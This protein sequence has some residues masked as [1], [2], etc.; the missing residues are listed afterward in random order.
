MSLVSINNFE[1]TIPNMRRFSAG[2]EIDSNAFLIDAAGEKVAFVLNIKKTG[3]ITTALI[4]V[5]GVTTA[6]TLRVS[7]Q[8]VD[9]TTGEPTGTSYGGSTAGTIASPSANTTYEVSFGTSASGTKGD[10]AAIVIEFDATVGSLNICGFDI[11]LSSGQE[12]FP[13]SMLYTT[14][15]ADVVNRF[16]ICALGYS[17]I[18]Y[19]TNTLPFNSFGITSFNNSS[20]P[21]E[22]ALYFKFPYPTKI[23]G[24]WF[25]IDLAADCDI[26]LYDV[27]G[28]TVLATLSLDTDLRG[29]TDMGYYK[30]NFSFSI[31]IQ[32]NRWY[33]LSIKPTTTTNIG[34]YEFTVASAAIMD[35]FD[36]GQYIYH[37]QRTDAGAWTE[38]TTKRIYGGILCDAFEDGNRFSSD[39]SI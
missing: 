4:R 23:S 30:M 6:Q 36:C 32:A 16:P 28:T 7:L 19:N 33:R 38:T 5:G 34:I 15:W 9:L 14:A 17:G 25:T 12:A 22:R 8:T 21:D 13:Y 37:S 18:Y 27:D 1:M 26:V 35:C 2:P 39:L 24:F 10:K 20:T 3:S 29:G 31:E 11:G